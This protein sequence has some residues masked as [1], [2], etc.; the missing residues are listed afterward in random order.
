MQKYWNDFYRNGGEF[1]KEITEKRKVILSSL[2]KQYFNVTKYSTEKPSLL[3][4]GCGKGD[5][6][7]GIYDLIG[8]YMGLDISGEALKHFNSYFKGNL[9]SKL[10]L[11]KKRL[12]L[13]PRAKYD[14]LVFCTILQH[15]PEEVILGKI[16]N[17]KR[18]T[19]KYIFL[20]ENIADIP[21]MPERFLWFRSKQWYI[22]LIVDNV[23]EL[24][25]EKEILY[26]GDEPHVTLVFRRVDE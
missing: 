23:W 7:K 19:K 6:T 24:F 20:H 26:H 16:K 25:E 13:S 17:L 11:P 3:E 9:S 4:F 5:I 10:L 12:P 21:S 2:I 1:D 15:L 22:D 18:I 14:I 8:N